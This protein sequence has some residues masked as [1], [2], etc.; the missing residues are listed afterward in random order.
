MPGLKLNFLKSAPQ[1]VANNRP[2]PLKQVEAILL[3][4][5]PEQRAKVVEKLLPN[6]YGLAL[7]TKTHHVLLTLL[8]RCDPLDR[9]KLLY[10]IRHK[11]A[12]LALSP[13][14]NKVLQKLVELVPARQRSEIADAF[15]LNAE[16]GEFEKLCQHPF[17]N[18]TAQRMME[19]KDC[20]AIL[21]P[22]I[23][24]AAPALVAHEY[25]MRVIDKFIGAAEDGWSVVVSE[26][27]QIDPE[28]LELNYGEDLSEKASAAL[29]KAVSKL[30]D[31]A[32]ESMVLCA[33][34]R[35]PLVPLPLKDAICVHLASN[36][37]RYLAPSEGEVKPQKDEFAMPDF[38]GRPAKATT[39]P[40]APQH[41]HTFCAM[42]EHGEEDQRE[43]LWTSISEHKDLLDKVVEDKRAISIAC[44]AVRFYDP[45]RKEVYQLLTQKGKKSLVAV[46]QDPVATLLLRV[47]IEVDQ[48][49]IFLTTKA[50][51]T[52]LSSKEIVELSKSPV[53]SPVLQKLVEAD[54]T[55]ATA[56]K[57]F[58][59][60]KPSLS[61]LVQH[62]AAAFL[63][64]AIL[65][66]AN[67][68]DRSA[69]TQTIV[70]ALG[71]L[72]SALAYPQGSRVLQKA[73]TYAD[74]ALIVSVI[75]QLVEKAEAEQNAEEDAQN[76][77]EDD[78]ESEES[79]EEEKEPLNRKEQVALNRKK[80]YGI[81]SN[82]VFAYA[83]HA[84]ACY[85]IQAL[86]LETRKRQLLDA[87]RRLMNQLKPHVF[88]L[89]VSP[90][91]GR[92]VLDAMLTAGSKELQD[93]IKNVVFLKAEAWLIDGPVKKAGGG[94]QQA[95]PTTRYILKR[96]R[97][98][99]QEESNA[100]AEPPKKKAKK[101]HRSLKR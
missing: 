64:Q 92:V 6:A 65:L 86:L 17:G 3:Y 81:T 82:A 78:D 14:G 48:E 93:A 49:G 70:E 62:P 60:L 16:D 7:N 30:F 28:S 89:A 15:V 4:G 2:V 79:E 91:A 22:V 101:L 35:H 38:S 68:E 8:E 39:D 99:T 27:L 13:V 18:H 23:E 77:A 43:L 73:L 96:Q 20:L 25:G 37:R 80:H 98:E 97:E 61:E 19:H 32:P 53:S 57:V 69:M 83:T 44:A 59:L 21:H 45:S 55:G 84:Q 26:V 66:G 85:V 36:V 94:K 88:D 41:I 46:A 42:L 10:N 52:I 1:R 33:L 51:S 40:L 71:D 74:D 9:V 72:K 90:W 100:K 50:L 11:I 56:A 87:R 95:D 58:R 5:R 54:P 63:V 34:L 76:E 31:K 29:E 67:A 47:F 24:K 12:D 75:E